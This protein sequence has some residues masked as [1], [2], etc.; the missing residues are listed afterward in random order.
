MPPRRRSPEQTLH[1]RR[2]AP[3]LEL[4]GPCTTGAGP[5]SAGTTAATRW[6]RRPELDPLRQKAPTGRPSERAAAPARCGAG[7][8]SP[9]TTGRTGGPTRHRPASRCR[10]GRAG[11]RSRRSPG[12]R[13][14]PPR[15][16]PRGGTPQP[17]PTTTP[18]SS[19]GW[20]F[21][22]T[23]TAPGA[24][25][26]RCRAAGR[27]CPPPTPGRSSVPWSEMARS[28]VRFADR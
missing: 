9:A 21:G 10:A 7:C 4:S 12:S 22:S 20:S 27:H 14:P 25:A 11:A 13:P 6:Q 18:R 15:T 24:G 3:E 5:I 19:P 1:L 8:G 17:P 16:P 2:R 23:T 26:A 28:G